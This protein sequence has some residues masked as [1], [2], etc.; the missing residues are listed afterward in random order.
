MKRFT[1]TL[2]WNDLWFLKL[3][4]KAKLL[5]I[6]CLDN[7]DAVGV[8]DLDLSMAGFYIGSEITQ[9]NISELGERIVRINDV[10][11]FIPKFIE[12]QYKK[13]SA[14][15]PGQ[16]KV[17]KLLE[18]YAQSDDTKFIVKRYPIPKSTV[19]LQERLSNSL[20]ARLMGGNVIVEPVRTGGK[21]YSGDS[22]EVELV[23]EGESSA[24]RPPSPEDV[25]YEA[26]PKKVGKPDAMKAIKRALRRCPF[27]KILEQTKKFCLIIT[28]SGKDLKYVP[29]PS[30]WFNQD[31]FN[32]N[33]D[34]TDGGRKEII[35]C[36]YGL[37]NPEEGTIIPTVATVEIRFLENG[38]V[39]QDSIPKEPHDLYIAV[40]EKLV[41]LGF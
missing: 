33:F 20:K 36:T 2:K 39:D 25:I 23:L 1:E 40:Q 21:R 28:E 4:I 31:R 7:C 34:D 16:M 30:T 19:S 15:C 41:A 6:Y 24:P 12:F 26:Y 10:K 14:D 29:N 9:E 32:D 8:I 38:E 18:K 17:V 22:G 37:K 35:E 5:W 13:L 11:F 27:D 3:S